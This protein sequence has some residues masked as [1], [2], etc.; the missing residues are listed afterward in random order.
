[1]SRPG[2]IAA[3]A[4]W[5]GLLLLLF[6]QE[7]FVEGKWQTVWWFRIP[8]TLAFGLVI[9]VFAIECLLQEMTV[10]RWAVSVVVFV[11][12]GVLLLLAA[13]FNPATIQ[14]SRWILIPVSAVYLGLAAVAA[15]GARDSL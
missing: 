13:L 4:G 7:F 1:V 14:L 9:L 15:V 2:A 11:V 5:V 10:R 8:A 6:W 3:A 12:F